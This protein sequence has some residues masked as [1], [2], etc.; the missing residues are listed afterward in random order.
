MSQLVWFVIMIA[1]LGHHIRSFNQSTVA[2]DVSQP[3]ESAS[4]TSFLSSSTVLTQPSPT[5][6]PT[7][8]LSKQIGSVPAEGSGP[9]AAKIDTESLAQ[10]ASSPNTAPSSSSVPTS[11]QSKQ[12]GSVPAQGSG[13]GAATFDLESFTQ[14]S[15][16]KPLA[17]SVQS[18]T[19]TSTTL[20]VTSGPQKAQSAGQFPGRPANTTAQATFPDTK[21]AS[22][23]TTRFSLGTGIATPASQLGSSPAQITTSQ[24]PIASQAASSSTPIQSGLTSGFSS[25]FAASQSSKLAASSSPTAASSTEASGPSLSSIPIGEGGNTAIANAYNQ[26]FKKLTPESSCNSKDRTQA[27]ACINDLFAECNEAGRYTMTAC[28]QGQQCF[29]LPMPAG[30]TGI[31]VQ[32]DKPSEAN[33]KLQLSGAESSSSVGQ[34]VTVATAP[35]QTGNPTTGTSPVPVFSVPQSSQGVDSAIP[36]TSS[37]LTQTTSQSSMT[38][39]VILSAPAGTGEAGQPGPSLSG[40]KQT[41]AT[42]VTSSTDVPLIISFPS[43]LSSTP[44]S[45]VQP[46][47]PTKVQN[48]APARTPAVPSSEA[49]QQP[50]SPP[51]P[52]QEP[53]ASVPAGVA[54]TTS[55]ANPGITI[56]PLGGD[57][58]SGKE[59]TVTVTVTTTERL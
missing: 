32:C 55:A 3:A 6:K 22:T 47:K 26:Q 8:G 42:A 21:P 52:S 44:Q 33:R 51:T 39:S 18:V 40:S 28:A 43:S 41:S 5:T 34:S 13:P 45:S 24:S 12:I 31:F 50:S 9:S 25:G 58:G 1:R 49:A 14:A 35:S 11:T 29:A 17:S 54:S 59:K 20:P 37:F 30:S 16:S 15:S 2:A 38:S 46:S 27:H 10:L 56:V 19:A 57:N 7:T 36:T 48:P 53:S 23:F 4:I